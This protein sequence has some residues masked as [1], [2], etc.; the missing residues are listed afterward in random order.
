[1]TL[2]NHK[3]SKKKPK[4]QGGNATALM[5]TSSM[6]KICIQFNYFKCFRK[7]K[8]LFLILAILHLC[9]LRLIHPSTNL[10]IM[11]TTAT[12]L[13]Y[14]FLSFLS[15]SSHWNLKNNVLLFVCSIF[16]SCELFIGSPFC[17]YFLKCFPFF[18]VPLCF[19]CCTLFVILSFLFYSFCWLSYSLCSFTYFLICLVFFCFSNLLSCFSF[20]ITLF[21]GL[22]SN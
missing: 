8:L 9:L 4:S 16:W 15:F 7:L 10:L 6:I 20:L 17:S 14:F 13:S 12:L 1:M 21:S 5:T 11:Q 3:E 18:S 19:L 2:K 22:S